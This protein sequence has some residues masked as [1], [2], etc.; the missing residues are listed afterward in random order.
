MTATPPSNIPIAFDYTS[1]DYFS[2]RE[3]L[4]AR[5]QDRVP[6]WTGSDPADFGIALVEAFAYMGDLLSYYIDRTANE[7][8]LTTATQRESVLNI[9]QTYGYVP[10]GYRAAT[11][12]LEFSNSSG[13][14]VTI[15]ESTVISGEIIVGDTVQTIYFTT[16]AEAIV[17]AQVGAVP[18][19]ETVTA[20]HGR[21][22]ILVSDDATDDG[23][24]IGTST[25]EPGMEFELG[26]TP[27]SDG[28]IELYVQ[29]GDIF[30][31]WTQV[32]HII[33]YGPTDQIFTT[34]SDEDNVVTVKFGDGVSGVIPTIYAEIRAKYNVGGGVEGN[35]DA[36]V[37]TTL[38]T[39]PGLS[40]V[41]VSAIQSAITVTNPAVAVGG[42]DPEETDQIRVAAALA[43]RANNR[44]VTLQDYADLSLAVTGVGK[45][46]AE[47]AVWSSVTVYIAPT[48]N[49]TDADESPGLD[50]LGNTTAEWDSLQT[51]VEDYLSDKILLGTSVTVSPPVYVDMV[52]NI[53]YTKLDQ[54][55]A[56]EV[57]A[58]IKNRLLT[59]FGYTGIDFQE[60]LYPQ[61]IEFSVLQVPGVK[62][63]KLTAFYKLG[64][65]VTLNT[66]LVAASD[67]IFRLQESNINLS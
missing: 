24:L 50:S 33:D 12:E 16:G 54:Y 42:A 62:T 27:V 43:L 26:E 61:D 45:A 11:V 59:D 29:D 25:G 22:V 55:T 37:L 40:E 1:K 60:T 41:Q 9:A 6:N 63:A 57:E 67:E 8:F 64:G 4:I 5:I 17:P 19:T 34:T 53:D 31:K 32:Q 13:S 18:G 14:S 23:E 47:A 38:D 20:T 30:T 49:V 65:S 35:V 66:S 48:R 44:A 46:N 28:S 36:D 10:A 58:A 39:L 56:A 51:D 52:T 2:I 15:P 21:S 7:A 3:E